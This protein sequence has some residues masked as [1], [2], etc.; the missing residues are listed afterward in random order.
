MS[1]LRQLMHDHNDPA[2][3]PTY[4]QGLPLPQLCFLLL[5][6]GAN[7][8]S[9]LPDI[10]SHPHAHGVEISD[11]NSLINKVDRRSLR[12][13]GAGNCECRRYATFICD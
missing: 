10:G 12:A 2:L 13:Y 8:L 4:V 6:C 1:S 11:S 7:R 9:L 5:D 3:L